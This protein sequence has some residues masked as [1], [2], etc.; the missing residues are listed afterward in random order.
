[1]TAGSL[2]CRL[3]VLQRNAQRLTFLG[4][5]WGSCVLRGEA[6]RVASRRAGTRRGEGCIFCPACGQFGRCVRYS[7]EFGRVRGCRSAKLHVL[8]LAYTVHFALH[9]GYDVE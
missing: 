7:A 5:W 4:W 1:M 3:S 2:R 9:G 6:R 8:C